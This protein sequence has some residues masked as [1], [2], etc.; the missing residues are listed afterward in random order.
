MFGEKKI[1]QAIVRCLISLVVGFVVSYSVFYILNY[2]HLAMDSE[3]VMIFLDVY[4]RLSVLQMS[5]VF[6][7]FLWLNFLTASVLLSS[8]VLIVLSFIIGMGSHLKLLY[9]GEPAYPSDIY[10]L[11]DVLFF[12]DMIDGKT[13]ALIV[14]AILL[15]LLSFIFYFKKR[16][17]KHYSKKVWL[18]RISGFVALS[19]MLVYIYNFNTPGNKVKA[20]FNDY[21]SWISYSQDENYKQNGVI[22][23]FLYNLKSPA[24]D[25]PEDY[26]KARI[27]E[28]V[29]K[30]E[31]LASE[32]NQTRTGSLEDVN[33]IYIMNET[34]S[35]LHRLDGFEV[36]GGDSLQN[37]R[38]AVLNHRHGQALSQV[39]GGGTANVEFEALTGISM[40]P[41]LGNISIPYI[42]MSD[43]I[44]QLPSITAYAKAANLYL[45]AIHPHNSTMYKRIDNYKTM[46]FDQLLFRDDMTFTDQIDR[47]PYISDEAAYQEVLKVM[48]DTEEKDFIHLVTMQNHMSYA[49]KYDDV[50]FEVTGLPKND[51]AEHYLKGMQYSDIAT[52][53]L[54][55][56]FDKM[57]E[58]V[59]VVFWGDHLPSFYGQEIVD[60]N[61]YLAMHE[62]PLVFYS[63]FSDESGDIG[64]ISPIYFI[65]H[66][67]EITGANVK[68]YVAMLDKLEQ[69]LPAF[70]KTFY[71][72]RESG[73][74]TKRGDLK[75]STQL[76]LEEYDLILYDITTG[77][78]YA[79]TYDFY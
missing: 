75:P 74:Q 50:E 23:G 47:S 76:L 71:L 19:V 7:L 68:P 56:A 4:T 35:D 22:S 46:G 79:K 38:E 12:V 15:V 24:L 11:K 55:D 25:R 61:G 66:L 6:V 13:I 1:K 39:Y 9:R 49:G 51:E 2:Y 36:T 40:E 54:F 3:A 65:N 34:F 17:K 42:H 72:E 28:I 10:F 29:E 78:N 69:A 77:H 53:E 44:K 21:T 73:I 57:D 58:K 16:K 67:L 48:A 63:N 59:I 41:L 45:T 52:S 70:E 14:G 18:L 33:V 30:Y 43:Q 20:M 27:E 37:Y 31:K 8:L 64:T 62:T 60:L 32:I 5:I 26:S